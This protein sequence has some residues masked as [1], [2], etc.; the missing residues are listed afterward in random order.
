MPACVVASQGAL[1]F[2]DLSDA[3]SQV[4]EVLRTNFAIRRKPHLGT[5]PQVYYIV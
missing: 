3:K 4:R 2:G 5:N 1:I